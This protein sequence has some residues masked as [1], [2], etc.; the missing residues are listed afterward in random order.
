MTSTKYEMVVID[1]AVLASLRSS[2][3]DSF[4]NYSDDIPFDSYEMALDWAKKIMDESSTPASEP[5]PIA[6]LDES[7]KDPVAIATYRVV[8]PNSENSWVKVLNI[9]VSPKFDV[10]LP[11]EATQNNWTRGAEFGKIAG[12]LITGSIL[13]ASE[14][15]SRTIK[16]YASNEITLDFFELMVDNLSSNPALHITNLD[17]NTQGNWLVFKVTS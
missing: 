1:D 6:I 11:S 16:F 8:H 17:A 9:V 2:W 4:C 13:K 3:L 5:S 15:E 10:R 14:S 12:A 7:T